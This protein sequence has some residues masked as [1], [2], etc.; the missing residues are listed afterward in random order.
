MTILHSAARTA[1]KRF[2]FAALL[3]L[4]IAPFV[5]G[6][7]SDDEAAAQDGDERSLY[8]IGEPLQDSSLAAVVTSEYG[9][10]TL[11]TME[12]RTQFQR[13]VQQVPQIGGDPAQSRELRKNILEDFIIT[14]ALFGEAEKLGVSAD[15]AAVNQR[16]EQIKAQF[17]NEQAFQQALAQDNLTIE[18]L[19]ENISDMMRQ[20]QM[21]NRMSEDVADPTEQELTEFR[22]S[23][24]QEVSAQHILFL[25]PQG[26]DAE[27][28]DSIKQVAETVL[29]SVKAGADFAEMAKRYSEDGTAQMG[30]DLGYFSRGQMVPPFEEATFA[31]ADSGDVTDDVVRTQYGYH[32]IRKTG[33]RT[34]E[35]MDTTRARQTLM[36]SRKREAVEEAVDDLRGKVTVRLNPVVVNTDLNAREDEE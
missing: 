25:T 28:R 26:A 34:G 17:P 16:I 3:L 24:A 1:L 2:S 27:T 32:I 7:G 30:G 21:L 15:T 12:F 11:T 8:T 18:E 14:H 5:A 35:M 4:F 22:E 6:C 19:R 31:L 36:Q 29:D 33:E 9:S 23:S 20:E 13:I 10:D